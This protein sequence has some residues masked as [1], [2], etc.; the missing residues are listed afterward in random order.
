[1][2]I[3]FQLFVTLVETTVK[4]PVTCVDKGKVNANNIFGILH[5]Q[6][7]KKVSNNRSLISSYNRNQMFKLKDPFIYNFLNYP[8]VSSVTYVYVYV[9][10]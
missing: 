7:Y 10:P 8:Q 6:Y 3:D 5:S 9:R 4:I 1:M 2:W